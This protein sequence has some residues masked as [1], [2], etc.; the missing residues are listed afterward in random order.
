MEGRHERGA[1]LNLTHLLMQISVHNIERTLAL[2][3]LPVVFAADMNA[4]LLA[5]DRRLHAR[6]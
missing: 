6:A 5:L 3:L 2:T 4:L 1:Q